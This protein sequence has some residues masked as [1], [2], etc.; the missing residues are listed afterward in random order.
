M[1]PRQRLETVFSGGVPD[2]TPVLSGWIANP[3]LLCDVAGASLDE[4]WEDARGTSIKAYRRMGVDGLIGVFVP[5][6]REDFRCVDI[7]TYNRAQTELTLDEV[8][9]KID[10][11]PDPET[12]EVEFDVDSQYQ[13]FKKDLIECQHK[14][15]D[16]LWMPPLWYGGARWE[17]YNDFGYEA[18]FLVIALYPDRA[19]KLM[20]VG[21]AVGRC[22]CEMVARAVREGIHPRAVLLGEDICTQRGPMVSPDFLE[23]Y[24]APQL[25][26]G[27]QPLLEVGCKPVWH[28]DGDVRPILDMLLDC[29]VQGL[30]GFQPECGM[31]IEWVARKRTRDG[32]P[33]LIFGPL[34]VTTELPV[35]RPEEIRARVRHAIDVCRGNADLALF[36]ANTINPDVP[37]ENI[38]AM[39]SAVIEEFPQG[40]GHPGTEG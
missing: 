6:S 2:R 5:S 22:L 29:G 9:A 35:L 18:Y 12:V 11:M 14:C 40:V 38:L 34:S 39:H 28:C 30:Q 19:Q 4:Y 24:Y 16:L 13:A 7:N 15:G 10:A 36:T 3:K 1:T 31:N 21:G 23:R 20:E 27:L 25:A 8:L 37:L 32:Q 33:L 26:Y 17:W